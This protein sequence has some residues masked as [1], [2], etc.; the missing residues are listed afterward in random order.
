MKI[1]SVQM[2]DNDLERW[3]DFIP[4]FMFVG[5]GCIPIDARGILCY[6]VSIIH[7]YMYILTM[8]T[9]SLYLYTAYVSANQYS[10]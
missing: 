5:C 2:N 9:Y 6:T 4:I 7:P 8:C 10:R 1:T 3:L